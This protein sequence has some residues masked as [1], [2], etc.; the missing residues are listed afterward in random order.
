MIPGRRTDGVPFYN[1]YAGCSLSSGLSRVYAS[2]FAI[3][4]CGDV[5]EKDLLLVLTDGDGLDLL[6]D[7]G[8]GVLDG[9][10]CGGNDGLFRLLA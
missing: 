10:N 3:L 4:K 7:V 5:R 9:L 2:T 6:N 1:E 8:D